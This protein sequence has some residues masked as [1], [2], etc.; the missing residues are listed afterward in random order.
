MVFMVQPKL[1]WVQSKSTPIKAS[2]YLEM[3]L[4][5]VA[6]GPSLAGQDFSLETC[7][8]RVGNLVTA[9]SDDVAQV[10]PDH[11]GNLLY[12]PP[13]KRPGPVKS[14]ARCKLWKASVW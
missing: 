8:G 11:L 4:I 13:T 6:P 5:A 1:A 2:Y 12:R 3:F 10:V 9:I 14:P 7:G